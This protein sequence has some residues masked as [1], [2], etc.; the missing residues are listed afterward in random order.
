MD[1][2]EKQLSDYDFFCA[3]RAEVAATIWNLVKAESDIAVG[4]GAEALS[5]A[6][7]GDWD[8]LAC[9]IATGA[10]IT[11]EMRLFISEVLS[12]AR[13][14]PRVKVSKFATELT[15]TAVASFVLAARRQGKTDAVGLAAKAF[16]RTAR[17]VNR[18]L[19]EYKERVSHLESINGRR[20]NETALIRGLFW[21]LFNKD[22]SMPRYFGATDTTEHPGSPGDI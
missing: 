7:A 6:R 21:R 12:G 10:R 11:P 19:A 2:D 9:H 18:D 8:P 20:L 3:H 22:G 17:Q 1:D 15:K 14:R 4:A 16:G 5:R 13:P